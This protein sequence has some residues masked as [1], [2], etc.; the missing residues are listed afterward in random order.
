M[1]AA[2]FPRQSERDRLVDQAG[3]GR[4]R[5]GGVRLGAVAFG[6]RRGDAALRPGRRGA[7]AER[8]RRNHGDR[9]WRQFQRAEQPGEAAADDDD[10]AIAARIAI[11]V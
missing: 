10:V 7:L 9:T 3:A 4:D 6:D 11:P 2:G 8:R 1:R 5:V